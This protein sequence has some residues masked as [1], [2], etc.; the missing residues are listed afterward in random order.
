MQ[1]SG[2]RSRLSRAKISTKDTDMSFFKKFGVIEYKLDGYSKEAMNIVT[3][4]ILKRLNADKS[5][6][7]QS[8]VVP[9]GATPESLAEELYSDAEKYWTILLVNGIVNPFTDWPVSSEVL[10]KIVE[11]KYGSTNQIL[12]FKDLNTGFFLDD[13]ADAQ[14]R[15]LIENNQPIPH[16]IHPVSALEYETTLNLEK[17][18]IIVV[19]PRYINR[20][21]DVFNKS[22]EGKA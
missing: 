19:A 13:V 20:F 1:R 21:V 5:F 10:E 3:A 22:I 6:V 18:K 2:Q 7:F 14:M 9:A 15:E 17:S 12:Y 8:Y 11:K 4:A 16:N